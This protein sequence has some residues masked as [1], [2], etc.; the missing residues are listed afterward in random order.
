M[1]S[2]TSGY[3]FGAQRPLPG[4]L[5]NLIAAAPRRGGGLHQWLFRAALHLQ[6]FRSEREAL[7]ILRE[8]TAGQ[9]IKPNELE[10][11][12]A[13]S[14][15]LALGAKRTQRPLHEK[16]WPGINE[17]QRQA[18][19]QREGGLIDLLEKS[20]IRCEEAGPTTEEIIDR[21]MPK[22]C[23]LCAGRGQQGAVTKS[24]EEWRGSLARQ[25]FIVP[26]PMIAV[27][28]LT[29]TGTLG[30][31]TLNNVGQRRFLV[32]DQDSGALDEQ[33]AILIHLSRIAPLALLVSTGGRG[34]HA[35]FY[36]SGKADSQLWFFMR[37]AVL[38]GACRSTWSRIQLV[39]MPG[40]I[41]DNG[42]LQRTLLFNPGVVR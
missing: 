31:R 12:I 37:M 32:I 11:A 23:L 24:R 27:Q 17:E 6:R 18:V 22:E 3:T 42:T 5:Q 8:K 19:I 13:N 38:L 26:S 25:E 16:K 20:P 40:G 7:A 36:C 33:A 14:R 4:Y 29:K 9:V 35:W 10:D 28:G 30:F 15:C 2:K 21:L 34:T 41:R 1:K 39:R